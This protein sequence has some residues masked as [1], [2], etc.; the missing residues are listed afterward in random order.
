MDKKPFFRIYFKFNRLFYITFLFTYFFIILCECEILPFSR[1]GYSIISLSFILLSFLRFEF[2]ETALTDLLI[3]ILNSIFFT[4]LFQVMLNCDPKLLNTPTLIGNIALNA[5][6]TYLLLLLTNRIRLSITISNLALFVFAFI[7][8]LVISF[9]GSEIRLSDF[10]SLKTAASVVGQY[11]IEFIT[12]INYPIIILF[13]VLFVFW[14]TRITHKNKKSQLPRITGA[15]SLGLCLATVS[16]CMNNSTNYMQVWAYEGTK[17]NGF[18]Y[19]FLIE[20]RDSRVTPP[21]KYSK[22]YAEDLLSNYPKT[23]SEDDTPHIIVVMSEAFSDLN[24]LGEVKTNVDP[25]EFYNSITDNATKGY[26]LSSVL[27]GN[28]AVSEWE[29]L[30]GNT[31]AFLPYG[32]VAYQQYVKND[33]NTLV[34]IMN[35]NGYTTVAMHP[36]LPTGWKRNTVYDVFGFDEIYFKDDLS[37]LPKIRGFVSDEALF[38]DIINRLNNKKEKEKLFLF[39]VTMQN[40]GGYEF[41]SFEEEVICENANYLSTNQYLTLI[42]K[43]DDALRKL[44]EFLEK[45]D[46]DT[47]LVFFGDHQPRLSGQSYSNIMGNE[48][49]TFQG[50]EKKHLVPFMI[51][52]NYDSEEE[53]I[54]VTSLNF[55]SSKMLDKAGIGLTPHF[56]YVNELSKKISAM[57][58]YG[59]LLP[60]SSTF[61]RISE[62]PEQIK[63]LLEEYKVIQYKNIFQP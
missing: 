22:E 50:T 10:Y 54:P 12:R 25:L 16:W 15:I 45:Y 4:L 48:Q 19:N 26:A 56:S 43:S 1:Q 30:T 23:N 62:A 9:R 13:F 35:D 57:N 58:F 36:Y 7:E 18:T 51:W 49:N 34:D 20:A 40:H 37:P 17:Y 52:T 6:L 61:V 31:Q 38:G 59:Y 8:Y 63:A 47:M 33:A 27:G 39:T 14:V 42:K 3:P 60:D 29:F 5:S 44:I 11:K 53:T 32:S 2:R 46:E 28:T 55:L 24:V 21:E 41:G